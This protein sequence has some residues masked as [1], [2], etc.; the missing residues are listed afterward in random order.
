VDGVSGEVGFEV[1]AKDHRPTC[2]WHSSQVIMALLDVD[3]D[4]VTIPDDIRDNEAL[5]EL[6]VPAV[7]EGE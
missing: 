3:V 4:G 1:A 2:R 7:D 5:G 6:E